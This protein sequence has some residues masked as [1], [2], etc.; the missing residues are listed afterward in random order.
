MEYFNGSTKYFNDF[1]SNSMK[2]YRD[3]KARVKLMNV[4]GLNKVNSL[5]YNYRVQEEPL[6]TRIVVNLRRYRELQV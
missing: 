2:M 1:F 4:D 6:L 3:V 5:L